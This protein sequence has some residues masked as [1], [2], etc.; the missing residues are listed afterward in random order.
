MEEEGTYY[1]AV[2]A[3]HGW[4]VLM[5][6]TEPGGRTLHTFD[7]ISI[8]PYCAAEYLFALFTALD[9]EFLERD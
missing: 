3:D 8:S 2:V 4:W 1:V 5:Q 6:L 7:S 9:L